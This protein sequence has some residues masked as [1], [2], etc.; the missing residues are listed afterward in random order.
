MNDLWHVS[1]APTTYEALCCLAD[2]DFADC[3]RIIDQGA[4]NSI[5]AAQTVIDA[6]EIVMNSWADTTVKRP[7]NVYNPAW[8]VIGP[9]PT[10]AELRVRCRNV[11]DTPIVTRIGTHTVR[12]VLTCRVSGDVMRTL[13]TDPPEESRDLIQRILQYHRLYTKK[14]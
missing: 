10:L 5:V 13:V 1:R 8:C 6:L 3:I 14:Q 11:L 4:K 2:M 7:G 9:Q 12:D